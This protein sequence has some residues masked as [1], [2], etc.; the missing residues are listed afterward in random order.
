MK[1]KEFINDIESIRDESSNNSKTKEVCT[2][3]LED[4]PV[5]VNEEI[6][7]SNSNDNKIL[8]YGIISS[9]TIKYTIGLNDNQTTN[10]YE[11]FKSKYGFDKLQ[12]I[13]TYH[14]KRGID[15]GP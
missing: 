8:T 5:V 2:L 14:H 15:I 9:N 12:G 7:L 1:L 13:S 10:M 6:K 3:I 4:K 11:Q